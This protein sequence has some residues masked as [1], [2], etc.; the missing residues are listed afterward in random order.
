MRTDQNK[1]KTALDLGQSNL[2]PAVEVHTQ[3]LLKPA[4]Q[5]QPGSRICVWPS[6]VQAEHDAKCCYTKRL[7][8]DMKSNIFEVRMDLLNLGALQ[9][10]GE[11]ELRCAVHGVSLE[12]EQD[13]WVRRQ[14]STRKY[15]GSEIALIL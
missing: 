6:P 4:L 8:G 11:L 13:T 10:C 3:H 1:F 2:G 15:V 14:P 9:K 12:P 7:Q 5:N